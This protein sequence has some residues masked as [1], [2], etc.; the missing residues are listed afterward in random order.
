[1]R[2]FLTLA[3]GVYGAVVLVACRCG[4]LP[5]HLVVRTADSPPAQ[6]RDADVCYVGTTRRGRSVAHTLLALRHDGTYVLRERVDGDVMAP[7]RGTFVWHEERL[8]L[9]P[10]SVDGFDGVLPTHSLFGSESWGAML[11][12]D[13]SDPYRRISCGGALSWWRETASQGAD[14]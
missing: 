14:G 8:E 4:C 9:S 11:R 12:E 13:G 2:L 7:T 5:Q 10:G 1:M 6:S 3:L